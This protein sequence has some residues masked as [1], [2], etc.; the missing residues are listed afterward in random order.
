M[1]RSNNEERESPSPGE[2][3]RAHG[4]RNHSLSIVRPWPLDATAYLA[5]GQQI[6][7]DEK[8]CT[9]FGS[10]RGGRRLHSAVSPCLLVN[11]HA[12][13]RF[14]SDVCDPHR[15]FPS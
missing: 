6:E 8:S 15:S 11:Q 5:L 12:D 3:E 14:V 2:T 4:V 10:C 13:A 9:V 1:R 7:V